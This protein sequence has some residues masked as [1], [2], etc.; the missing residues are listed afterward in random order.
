MADEPMP[1]SQAKTIVEMSGVSVDSPVRAA[2]MEDFLPFISSMRA[3]AAARSSSVC[4]ENFKMAEATRKET[5][6]APVTPAIT[7][8]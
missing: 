8:T 7:P 1:A 3:V 2:P 5:M 6:A 4:L